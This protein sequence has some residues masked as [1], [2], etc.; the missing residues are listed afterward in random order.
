MR[1]LLTN[2][3]G[4]KAKGLEILKRIIRKIYKK[5][6]IL[7]YAPSIG[8]TGAGRSMT[9]GH[10]KLVRVKEIE[11]NEFSVYGT[12]TDCVE[13]ACRIH[14]IDLVFS[15]VN[16]GWNLGQ[17][18]YLSGTIQAAFHAVD[19][20]DVPA[21]ALSC[22]KDSLLSGLAEPWIEKF[23]KKIHQ[24]KH[25]KGLI[26]VNFPK[27]VPKATPRGVRITDLGDFLASGSLEPI[28]RSGK[29]Q[30]FDLLDPMSE[31]V[32]SKGVDTDAGAIKKGWIAITEHKGA[33]F[34]TL[35]LLGLHA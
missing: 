2:D 33:R 6:E 30:W 34:R 35:T 16:H 17:D 1:I 7:I 24:C 14:K 22:D 9:F 12:P 25:E 8:Y 27:I 31:I 26:N 29:S 23:I 5:A 4:I 19:Y 18:F 32:Q 20:F 3:D 28:K 11:K 13:I 21:L 15:G 10:G